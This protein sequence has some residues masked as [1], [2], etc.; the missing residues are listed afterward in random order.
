MKRVKPFLA[1]LLATL[2]TGADALAQATR[3]TTTTRTTTTKT[4]PPTRRRAPTKTTSTTRTTTT[5][6][7]NRRAPD[8]AATP[9]ATAPP[10]SAIDARLTGL[11]RLLPGRSD[12]PR[13]A[14][15][16]AARTLPADVREEM[17]ARLA[18]RLD[19][20][21]Q[22]AIE[23]RGQSITIA[24]SRAP[25]ITFDADGRTRTEQATD[26]HTVSTRAALA[27]DQ[28]SVTSSGSRD[29]EF[30]VFFDTVDQGR[31]LRVTRRIYDAR[32]AGPVVVQSLYDKVSQLA[33][34]SIYGEPEGTRTAARGGN[35][36][37]ASARRNAPTQ[38]QQRQTQQ[39]P[40]IRPPAPRRDDNSPFP[41]DLSNDD[42]N[43]AARQPGA[44]NDS[45]VIGDNTQFTA[46]LDNDLS[47]AAARE[48]DPVTLTVRAPAQFAGAVIEGTI[49]RVDRGGRVAGRAELAFEFQRLRLRDG[50]AAAFAGTV[51]EVRAAGDENVRVDNEGG[52]VQE[53]DS[54]T[55]RTVQR[56]AIGAA[57]GAIIGAIAGGGK[58]AAIGAAAGAG[59]G[60]GS[61]YAQGRDD[62]NL[63]RGTELLIRSN[64][65]R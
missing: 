5:T 31:R 58:G 6:T 65:S 24:S 47:T 49:A 26:G 37:I 55:D 3:R 59:A 8:A 42:N 56:A 38:Q 28:L 12:D 15:E 4:A 54:Q 27:D 7:N 50:R 53:G 45:F 60:A 36:T 29:D 57:I 21:A 40:V 35:N 9:P 1:L 2:L 20:P 17:L 34:F 51:L 52:N 30:A 41:P 16:R 44:R 64:G 18:A 22:L 23:R 10:L 63:P 62:L 25:Q 19:S 48:G 39:R 33:R 32:L 14:A 61:V 46:T 43:S 11:Y 13:A